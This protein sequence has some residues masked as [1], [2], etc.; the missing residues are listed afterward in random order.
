MEPTLEQLLVLGETG[1]PRQTAGPASAVGY[2]PSNAGN[3]GG[4][5]TSSR[6]A[7]SSSSYSAAAAAPA[8]RPTSSYSVPQSSGQP[9]RFDPMSYPT[10]APAPAPSSATQAYLM[11]PPAAVHGPA[12]SS[13]LASTAASASTGLTFNGRPAVTSP[14]SSAAAAGLPNSGPSARSHPRGGSSS[15]ST[16]GGAPQ[17]QARAAVD[18]AAVVRDLRA[19]FPKVEEEVITEVVEYFG[20]LRLRGVCRLLM[21]VLVWVA[22]VQFLGWCSFARV[23]GWRV[24]VCGVHAAVH[25]WLLHDVFS[26]VVLPDGRLEEAVEQLQAMNDEA[27]VEESRPAP[28]S[29][30]KPAKKSW[31]S[32]RRKSKP[33]TDTATYG[34]CAALVFGGGGIDDSTSRH[35]VETVTPPT[36]AGGGDS[37][38]C[39]IASLASH[40]AL[41]R[42]TAASAAGVVSPSRSSQAPAVV[43]EPST[44][45]HRMPS[46]PEVDQA[47]RQ[48]GRAGT[49]P[50]ATPDIPVD[51]CVAGGSSRGGWVSE[52][53]RCRGVRCRVRREVT[54][55]WCLVVGGASGDVD[56]RFDG[57]PHLPSYSA[58][59]APPSAPGTYTGPSG[60]WYPAPAGYAAAAPGADCA[61]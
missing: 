38:T 1:S 24:S 6:P 39:L 8:P 54:W 41:C 56:Y 27:A 31:F 22:C 4:V 7:T 37:H 26:A 36:A 16:A 18:V 40:S 46:G 34:S 23:V 14:A 11:S 42:S 28:T 48:S 21:L 50:D 55:T 13:L 47:R 17:G 44:W 49:R 32:F 19:L 52:W 35:G 30:S 25:R 29:G 9:P 33:A 10:P 60:A 45:A 51:R 53:R 61:G 15:S 57:T 3:A 58:Q 59:Y 20:T 12:S 2:S 43:A 5:A